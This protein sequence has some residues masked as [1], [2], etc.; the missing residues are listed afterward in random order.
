LA[1]KAA[2]DNVDIAAFIDECRHT[3]TSEAAGHED[4]NSRLKFFYKLNLF[5]VTE[6]KT[7]APTGN[8]LDRKSLTLGPNRN[9]NPTALTAH[10]Y[11]QYFHKSIPLDAHY[12]S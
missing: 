5:P 2:T 6:E 10:A 8:N 9:Q 1:L 11:K 12:A 4:T 7:T 3:E